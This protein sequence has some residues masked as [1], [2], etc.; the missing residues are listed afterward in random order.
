M[1]LL[2]EIVLTWI[3]KKKKNYLSMDIET[4]FLNGN[5]EEE[6]FTKAPRGL[7]NMGRIRIS[8]QDLKV[9]QVNIWT[10]SS[11]KTMVETL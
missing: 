10:F 6:I 9:K 4:A 1:T 3:I 2:F 8:E 5:L 11:S 7:S